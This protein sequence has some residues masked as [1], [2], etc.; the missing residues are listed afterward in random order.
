MN[1]RL[2][3][4]H[5]EGLKYSHPQDAIRMFL[6]KQ[7]PQCIAAWS[8]VVGCKQ[9]LRCIYGSD[10]RAAWALLIDALKDKADDL[11]AESRC[12]LWCWWKRQS[13]QA[14]WDLQEIKLD[15]KN[16]Q[17]VDK[18]ERMIQ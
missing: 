3:I 10:L 4:A 9:P 11:I 8:I 6:N 13:R 14:Y 16:P 1:L 2:R 15:Q 12:R 17:Y 18:N 7:M 5:P